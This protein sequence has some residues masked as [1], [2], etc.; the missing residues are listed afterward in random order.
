M[1]EHAVMASLSSAHS[2]SKWLYLSLSGSLSLSVSLAL[3]L[4]PS[5]ST[6]RCLC[7]WYAFLFLWALQSSSATNLVRTT[8][9]RGN[10]CLKSELVVESW[11]VLSLSLSQMRRSLKQFMTNFFGTVATNLQRGWS[12]DRSID[13]SIDDRLAVARVSICEAMHES[14]YMN[15][16]S[17]ARDA[18]WHCK[19]HVVTCGCNHRTRWCISSDCICTP[20]RSSWDCTL[21]FYQSLS[22]QQQSGTQ[23]TN[24]RTSNSFLWGIAER[25]RMGQT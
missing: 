16:L 9:D 3:L 22:L 14:S 25:I 11:E 19:Q 1:F 21:Q 5:W 4:L 13:R 18:F 2:S 24:H 8:I 15:P 12:V 20:S 7:K 23:P 6:W 17:N 10:A